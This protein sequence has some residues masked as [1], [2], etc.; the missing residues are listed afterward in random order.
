LALSLRL[1][2]RL[3]RGFGTRTALRFGPARL[4]LELVGLRLSAAVVFDRKPAR[5]PL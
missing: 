1:S 5:F 3:R 2:L 4:G